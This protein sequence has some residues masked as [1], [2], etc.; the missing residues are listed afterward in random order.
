MRALREEVYRANLELRDLGLVVATFGNVSGIHRPSG[1]VA[2]KPSGVAYE[3]LSPESM[4]LVDLEARVLEGDLNPS[5]DTRTHVRLY[6]AFSEIGGV[7]H[8]HSRYATAW[9]QARRPLPCFGTTHAD[10]FY[11]EVPCTEVMRDEQISRDY[12]EETAVQILETFARYDY[13]SVPGVLVACH[14]PFTWGRSPAQAVYHSLILEYVAE[15]G[16]HSAALAPELTEI[17]QT[18]MDKHYLRK[19]GKDAYYG[20]GGEH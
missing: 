10:T 18:L 6:E 19:H 3:E 7:V 5:S 1:V 13:R 14:G 9:A 15:L 11:G 8:T 12:E 16:L 20:Q 4:V 2:I 17:K